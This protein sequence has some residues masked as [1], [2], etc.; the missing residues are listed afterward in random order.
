MGGQKEVVM[1]PALFSRNGGS[2][3]IKA[4]RNILGPVNKNAYYINGDYSL[5]VNNDDSVDPAEYLSDLVGDLNYASKVQI[6]NALKWAKA[7]ADKKVNDAK[8][9]NQFSDVYSTLWDDN[10]YWVVI[11]KDK[12]TSEDVIE[13]VNVSGSISDSDK[14]RRASD[15]DLIRSNKANADFVKASDEWYQGVVKQAVLDSQNVALD[16]VEKNKSDKETYTSSRLGSLLG[17]FYQITS[18]SDEHL[19]TQ[20]WLAASVSP[21]VTNWLFRQGRTIISQDGNSHFAQLNKNSTGSCSE[22]KC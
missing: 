6:S 1:I 12:E 11:S 2:V 18:I 9:T 15:L 20:D 5:N 22:I 17:S 13:Q 10:S 4:G 14:Q 8:L 21:L 16:T 3:S 7:Q 19:P